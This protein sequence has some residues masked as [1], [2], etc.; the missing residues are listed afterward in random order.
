MAHGLGN[1]LAISA[2]SLSL[3]DQASA[4]ESND[5]IDDQ[6][7][8]ETDRRSGVNIPNN[9]PSQPSNDDDSSQCATTSFNHFPPP[10][11]LAFLSPPQPTSLY[12]V[13]LHH[14]VRSAPSA[15]IEPPAIRSRI[16]ALCRHAPRARELAHGAWRHNFA[17]AVPEDKTEVFD[18]INFEWMFQD[19]SVEVLRIMNK[20]FVDGEG[21]LE[22]DI[23]AGERRVAVW[24]VQVDWAEGGEEEEG[25]K[26][27]E[28]E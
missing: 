10:S 14:L 6:G 16:L 24:R 27:P 9:P 12:I 20:G 23:G 15:T 17:Y 19:S 1:G 4:D 28:S 25:G 3:R 21:G 26:T 22:L 18:G 2:S 13:T 11:P 5:K 7:D 8:R